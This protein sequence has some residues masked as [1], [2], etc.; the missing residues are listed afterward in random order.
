MDLTS[1]F[2]S[3]DRGVSNIHKDKILPEKYTMIQKISLKCVKRKKKNQSPHH[4]TYQG[5]QSEQE[6]SE[7]RI[8]LNYL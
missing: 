8:E 3:R 7:R 1:L 2:D 5:P 4:K 6:Y